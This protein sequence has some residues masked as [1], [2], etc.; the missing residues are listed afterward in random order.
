MK[1]VSKLARRVRATEEAAE[2]AIRLEQ[3]SLSASERVE[4]LDWLKESPVHVAEM[5]RVLEVHDSLTEYPWWQDLAPAGNFSS[6]DVIPIS[7]RTAPLSTAAQPRQA[8]AK[9]CWAAACAAAALLCSTA[10]LIGQGAR[11]IV[12]QT[13]PGERRELTLVDGSTVTAA[14]DTDLRIRMTTDKRLVSLL[15]GKALFKVAKDK[16]HPFIVETARVQVVAVGTIFSVADNTNA[17]VVTVSEGKVT[18]TARRDLRPSGSSRDEAGISLTAHQQVAIAST[19]GLTPIHSVD[20]AVEQ[21]WEETRI[22]FERETVAAVVDQFNAR[23]RIKIHVLDPSL[24]K[25]PVSGVFGASDPQ[26]FVAFL[27]AATG[28]TS[29]RSGP[30]EIVVSAP[31]RSAVDKKN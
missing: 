15:R 28:A 7:S 30:E 29:V 14:A 18:V 6:A 10:L 3:H 24:A 8:R 25:T 22:A 31:P 19:G 9:L 1:S 11:S 13:Q 12:I 21:S 23:N 5:L 2:W 27:Q 17:V 16:A 20:G 4:L 26:S